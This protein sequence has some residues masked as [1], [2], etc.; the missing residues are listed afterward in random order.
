MHVAW[1]G[2]HVT[3]AERVHEGRGVLGGG[4]LLAS[5]EVILAPG[6]TYESPWLYAA[7]SA[8]GDRR[9]LRRVPHSGCVAA[10]RTR[11]GRGRSC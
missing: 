5:G 6:E 2:N 1:S 7:Y 8:A 11:P 3:Y 10:P 4:E 9:Y